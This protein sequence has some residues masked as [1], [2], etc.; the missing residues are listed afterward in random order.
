[1]LILWM[2]ITLVN[3]VW[4]II[5][6]VLVF[7]LVLGNA[8]TYNWGLF[9]TYVVVMLLMAYFEI[10]VLSLYH[11]LNYNAAAPQITKE[12]PIDYMKRNNII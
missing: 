4:C 7:A 8:P 12:I 2:I 9:G 11:K 1:M 3:I 10:V 5:S 6:I